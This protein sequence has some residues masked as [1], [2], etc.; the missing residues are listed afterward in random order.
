MNVVIWGGFTDKATMEVL[1]QDCPWLE[2]SDRVVHSFE[3]DHGEKLPTASRMKIQVVE[4]KF[5]MY[6][7]E[8]YG[9]RPIQISVNSLANGGR[10]GNIDRRGLEADFGDSWS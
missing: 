5:P 2:H 7:F 6:D 4:A 9:E 3:R 10:F 8:P 1:M